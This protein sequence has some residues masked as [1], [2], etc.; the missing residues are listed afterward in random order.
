[1]SSTLLC[2]VLSLIALLFFDTASATCNYIYIE[3][4]PVP[5][6]TCYWNTPIESWGLYC[7]D[8]YNG[9]VFSSAKVLELYFPAADCPGGLNAEDSQ[10]W[11][12]HDC[13]DDCY[14]SGSS[15]DCLVMTRR[16]YD[17]N[18]G[19]NPGCNY[20]YYVDEKFVW[21][22]CLDFGVLGSKGYT[23]TADDGTE[24]GDGLKEVLY[25]NT[26]C[27]GA[28]KDTP[29]PSM[30]PAPTQPCLLT[31]CSGDI[32]VPSSEKKKSNAGGVA[33]AVIIVLLVLIACGVGIWCWMKRRNKG[34]VTFD[35]AH[36][37]D[38]TTE[39]INPTTAGAH[40]DDHHL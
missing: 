40:Q 9:T 39:D 32:V 29:A 38:V 25:T 35:A 13:T 30:T 28:Q 12:L 36:H 33:A 15:S 19:F 2:S 22:V 1:M 17:Y 27:T 21:D 11:A 10:F 37:D 23:C 14:C 34:Q 26:G 18:T 5:L 20:T 8:S 16:K 7:V 4:A 3:E 24:N 6:E 31:T